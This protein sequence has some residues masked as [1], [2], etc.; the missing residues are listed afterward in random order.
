MA[1][2]A[3]VSYVNMLN[4]YISQ[5]IQMTLDTVH[6][7]LNNNILLIGG[8]GAGKTFRF[9]GPNIMQMTSS[10]VVTDP[11]GKVCKKYAGILEMF[12][13]EIKVINVLNA[14]G[15]N[16]STR[17]N[18][19]YYIENDMD[20]VK[21]VTNFME[22]T[23]DKN[24]QSG[25][26]FWTDMAGLL[27][28]AF[29]YYAMEK[30]VEID[31]VLHKD[32]KGV[33]ELVKRV[34]VEEDD[35]GV[36][37]PSETDLL[38]EAYKSECPDSLAVT[39]YFKALSGAADTDRSIVSTLTSRTTALQTKEIQELLSGEDEL[40]IK[41]IGT[42]KTAVFCII[43]DNDSTYNFLIGMMY[44][45]MFQQMYYQAD[46]VYDGEL[47]IHVTFMMDEFANVSLPDD[48]P[49]K[50][51]TMRSRG[52]SCIIIIQNMAQL[53][54]IFDKDWEGI[55]GNC[56]TLIYLGGN[57]KE[58][59][60]YLSEYIGNWT[61]DK[62]TT[63]ITRGSNGSSSQNFDV[64][65]RELIRP[66]EIRKLNKK[67]CIV[68]IRGFDPIMDDKINPKKHPLWDTACEVRKHYR[69]DAR[70]VRAKKRAE[71]GG[72]HL[73]DD[74]QI[75]KMMAE[76]A[77]EQEEYEVL[78]EIAAIEGKDR[79]ERVKRKIIELTVDEILS[80]NA[81]EFSTSLEISGEKIEENRAKVRAAIYEKEKNERIKARQTEMEELGFSTD[82]AS[83]MAEAM[84]KIPKEKVLSMF[85]AAMPD[86]VISY[87]AS[88]LL[89]NIS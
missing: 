71:N 11:K 55:V 36:R 19:F 84:E 1:V 66:E 12:G 81:D 48:F 16:R 34:K 43:P 53:K 70:V 56:D 21:L 17:Y 49:K 24:A 87:M 65:G 14:T 50:L 47:P 52:I 79:P 45:Q 59:H 23:K 41:S 28:Q 80:L 86:E 61:I 57:E 15:M 42:R 76:D 69:F 20:V 83:L 35:N 68:L 51:A 6:T 25:E 9:V 74:A 46:F 58:T 4:R 60:K 67:K 40:D 54:K 72:M 26:A 22:N 75:L 73:Y 44:T 39:S 2:D 18:P 32:F 8:S 31:G 62:K 38:F 88:E 3:Q 7:D 63:G 78:C 5:S 85:N 10:F 27:L 37:C 29:I 89:K 82:S 13:Y 77:Y 30:G 33:M 64:L